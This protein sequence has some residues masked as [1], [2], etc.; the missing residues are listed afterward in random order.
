M[1]LLKCLAIFTLYCLPV[2]IPTV[3][4]LFYLERRA[5]RRRI[6]RARATFADAYNAWKRAQYDS[7]PSNV[8]VLHQCAA[9]AGAHLDI[10]KSRYG[11]LNV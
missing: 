4:L 7:Y 11:F 6:V 3:A 2:I 5:L 8:P 10:L 1:I 9:Q